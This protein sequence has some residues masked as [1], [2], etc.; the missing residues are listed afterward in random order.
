MHIKYNTYDVYYVNQERNDSIKTEKQI[1]EE[2]DA[3]DV[4]MKNYKKTYKDN[5]I[6]KDVFMS[7]MTE[8]RAISTALHWVLGESERWD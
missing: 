6:P 3:V 5:E 8:N 2:I 1:R 4:T 7:A